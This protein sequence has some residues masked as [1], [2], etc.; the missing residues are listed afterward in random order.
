MISAEPGPDLLTA[1]RIAHAEWRPLLVLIEEALGEIERPEWQA[2]VPSM[3]RS[4]GGQEPLLASAA[5]RVASRPIERWVRRVLVTAA[6]MG[7]EA[8][9]ADAATARRI[10]PRALFRAAVAQ[11]V[12]RL[13]IISR[14]AGD[15]RGVLHGL[16]PLIAMPLLHACRRAW[17]DSEPAAWPHGHCRTCGA[18]PTLAEIRGLEGARHLRCRRCGGDWVTEWLRCPFCGERDHARLGSLVSADRLGREK[19][20]VCDGCRGYLKTITTFGPIRP[21]DVVLEDLATVVLDVVAVERGYRPPDPR[22]PLA[23]RIVARPSGLR[24][25]LARGGV[26]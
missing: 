18:W 6:G 14:A 13:D 5:I 3:P 19:I 21:Q 24:G 16:A 20:E 17:A 23:V 22:G 4:G 1:L 15:R 26:G 9:F 2:S 12:T 25:L 10:D 7:P 11:D 8:P